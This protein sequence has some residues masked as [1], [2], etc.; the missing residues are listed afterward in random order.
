MK[1]LVLDSRPCNI[2]PSMWWPLINVINQSKATLERDHVIKG[3]HLKLNIF[4]CKV[5]KLFNFASQKRL[6]CTHDNILCAVNKLILKLSPAN[7][8]QVRTKNKFGEKAAF[9]PW[10]W[11]GR[12]IG[13]LMVSALASGS[14]GVSSS[15][16]RGHCIDFF[17]K[18]L[19]TVHGYRRI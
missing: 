5:T 9:Y 18:T 12:G 15:P 6:P 3:F 1:G 2:S 7:K 13:G 19:H 14:S 16:D 10:V 17:G 4:S 11:Q 8:L